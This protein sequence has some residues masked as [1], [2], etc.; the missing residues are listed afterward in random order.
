MG[1]VVLILGMLALSFGAVFGTGW[2]LFLVYNGIAPESWVYLDLW[3]AIGIAFL[4]SIFLG[5]SRA[6][7]SKS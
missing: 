4:L 6:S 1:A 5:G 7:V 3:P 2:L